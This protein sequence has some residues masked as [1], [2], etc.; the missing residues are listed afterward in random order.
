MVIVILLTKEDVK[1]SKFLLFA[2]TSA[3]LPPFA[4]RKVSILY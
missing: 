1:C 2:R 3:G 4:L